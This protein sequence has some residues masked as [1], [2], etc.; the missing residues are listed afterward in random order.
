MD[1]STGRMIVQYVCFNCGR[2]WQGTN[3]GAMVTAA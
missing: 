1:L 2:H 3:S